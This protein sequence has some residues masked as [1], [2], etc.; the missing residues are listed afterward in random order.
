MR[1]ATLVAQPFDFDRLTVSGE[2]QR[3]AE[4][5]G[6][7]GSFAY[8]GAAGADLLVYRAGGRH[9]EQ[10]PAADV[11]GPERSDDRNDR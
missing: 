11:D 9:V 2:A 7:V 5:V 8:F 10:S 6:S 1:D 3:I 4:G